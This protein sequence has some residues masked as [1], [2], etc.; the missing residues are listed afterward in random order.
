MSF[1]S[2]SIAFVNSLPGWGGGEKW[3]LEAATAMTERGH[4]V[5]IVAQPESILLGRAQERGLRSFGVAMHGIVDPRTLLRLGWI[6]RRE[7]IRVAVASQAR[8][9][10]L[11]GISQ[12]GRPGFRMIARRGSPDPIKDV[13]HF[14]WVYQRWVR[15]LIV[16]AESLVSSVCDGAPWFDRSRLVVLHNGIEVDAYRASAS[17]E[18]ARR[19]LNIRND[20]PVVSM[21]GEVGWRK[22]Q[23]TFVRAIAA[24]APRCDALFLIAGD[25][26]ERSR[27][28]AESREL[29]LSEDR[30]RWL[31]FRDDIPDLL[32]LSDL[33]VLPSREEGFPNTLLEAMALGRCVVATPVDGIP[34]LVVDGGTGILTPMA[35]PE[36]LAAHILEV[37]G[38][39][40]RRE[41]LGDAGQARVRREFSQRG[42]MDQLDAL[43]GETAVD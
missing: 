37:L 1:I 6:L 21:V 42:K 7:R 19:A 40:E 32:A 18:R 29:G 17:A 12:F 20:R 39:R 24:I 27:L 33:V 8:E 13:W 9:I 30:L 5:C 3:F 11:L 35:D 31:G 2:V 22:D 43:I 4:R 25:G 38:D 28:E 36:Q 16:N 26:P 23:E 41:L 15:R 14:R 34:E 10:R